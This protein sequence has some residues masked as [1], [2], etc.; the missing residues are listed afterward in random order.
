MA[1]PSQ[2][3]VCPEKL[4]EK[5]YAD[6]KRHATT[7]DIAEGDLILLRQNRENKLSPTFETEPYCVL[8]KNGNAFVIENSASQSK[9][10]NAGHMKKFVDPGTEKGATETE[11]PAPSV[12][13]DTP[14]EGVSFEQDPVGGIQENSQTQAVPLPLTPAQEVPKRRP[15]RKG[16][17][18]KWMKDFL[19]Q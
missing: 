17:T 9:M 19:W 18:P 16:E 2:R 3:K 4:R 12:T 14:K 6:S 7:S 8:E 5:E 11:L 1:N 15:V 13:T 10:R